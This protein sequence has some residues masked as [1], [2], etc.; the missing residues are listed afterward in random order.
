MSKTHLD[1]V[2][3]RLLTS[4][5]HSTCAPSPHATMPI[6]TGIVHFDNKMLADRYVRINYKPIRK[7]GRYCLVQAKAAKP[8]SDKFVWTDYY[9]V[10]RYGL[11][12]PNAEKNQPGYLTGWV[13]MDAGFGHIEYFLWCKDNPTNVVRILDNKTTDIAPMVIAPMDMDIAP[14]VIDLTMDIA[15]MV[16][17]LMSDNTK[18]SS[19]RTT[20]CQ[21]PTSHVPHPSRSGCFIY[22]V[23]PP[24]TSS[25][26]KFHFGFKEP[27]AEEKVCILML[28]AKF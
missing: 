24:S 10:K 11:R 28:C 8:F 20:R 12:K 14:M 7:K 4:R 1:E 18:K 9:H 13:L 15:P 21:G 16:I 3:V 25:S 17:D 19:T 2:H 6:T 26:I 23:F 22:F 5:M 27:C